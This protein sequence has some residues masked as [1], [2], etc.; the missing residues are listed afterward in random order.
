M[1]REVRQYPNSRQEGT[2]GF[3]QEG[4]QGLSMEADL[5]P[6]SLSSN[7]GPGEE[8]WGQG[9][10]GMQFQ[11]KPLHRGHSSFSRF[12]AQSVLPPASVCVLWNPFVQPNPDGLER[13][14][15]TA[16]SGQH[17]AVEKLLCSW[18]TVLLKPTRDH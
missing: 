18:V 12:Q 1:Q 2:S 14:P 8:S 16:A 13:R 5:G 15:V 7:L 11:D 4:N 17:Q 10:E 9:R 3:C 6:V